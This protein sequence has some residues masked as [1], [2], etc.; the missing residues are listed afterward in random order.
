LAVDW[1]PTIS[2]HIHE[3]VMAGLVVAQGQTFRQPHSVDWE[4][5]DK[6]LTVVLVLDTIL[7]TTLVVAVAVQG[8]MAEQ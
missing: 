1:V 5:L 7:E 2:E 3:A 8:Q 6:V 4:P